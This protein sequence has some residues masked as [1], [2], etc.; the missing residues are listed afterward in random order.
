MTLSKSNWKWTK[1]GRGRRAARERDDPSAVFK[2]FVQVLAQMRANARGV[3]A[4]PLAGTREN[5]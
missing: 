4:A 3:H 5:G 1:R 2:T